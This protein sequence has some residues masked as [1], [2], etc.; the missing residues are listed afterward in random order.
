LGKRWFRHDG[1]QACTERKTV[2]ISSLHLSPWT[3]R[4]R[5]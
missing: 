1:T 4:F 3:T 2:E 5:L